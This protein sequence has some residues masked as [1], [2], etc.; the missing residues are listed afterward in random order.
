MSESFDAFV[1][2]GR[3]SMGFNGKY[4]SPDGEDITEFTSGIDIYTFPTASL[5]IKKKE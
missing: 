5:P 2:V 3:V 1:A 4:N